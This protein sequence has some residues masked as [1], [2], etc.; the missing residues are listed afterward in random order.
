MSKSNLYGSVSLD[1]GPLKN[2]T[3]QLLLY[4]INQGHNN[5]QW[6]KSVLPRLLNEQFMSMYKAIQISADDPKEMQFMGSTFL[7][8]CHGQCSPAKAEE[9]INNH[10]EILA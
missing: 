6:H 7:F 9:W 1:K 3:S 8:A 4:I 5:G 10:A 2:H